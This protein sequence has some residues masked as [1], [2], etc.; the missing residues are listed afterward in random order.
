MPIELSA[1][2]ISGSVALII[3][4]TSG[5]LSWLQLRKERSRWIIDT[6]IGWSLELLRERLRSYPGAFLAIAPLS[7]GAGRNVDAEI[8]GRVV[9]DLNAWLYSAG[10]MCAGSATR[11]AI[12][13]LRQ[14]CQEWHSAGGERPRELYIFRNFAIKFLRLDLDLSGHNESWDFSDPAGWLRQLGDDLRQMESGRS[15]RSGG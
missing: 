4:V 8:A 14:S 12:I 5:L 11:A 1:A 2:L 13:G 6:K 3:G 15:A 7:H 10:G 9:E